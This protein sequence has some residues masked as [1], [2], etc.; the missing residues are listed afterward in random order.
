MGRVVALAGGEACTANLKG[1]EGMVALYK[2]GGG[3]AYERMYG[4][5]EGMVG[6]VLGE[7]RVEGDGKVGVGALQPVFPLANHE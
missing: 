5:E 1:G 3:L 6:A 4:G 7:R 2:L